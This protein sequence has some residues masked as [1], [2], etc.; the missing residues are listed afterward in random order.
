LF[1]SKAF[2]LRHADSDAVAALSDRAFHESVR[3]NPA[4][5]GNRR[6]FEQATRNL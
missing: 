4:T 3:N 1:F 6:A 5:P 2:F